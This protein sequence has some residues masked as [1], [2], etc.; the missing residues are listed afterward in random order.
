MYEVH[1]KRIDSLFATSGFP[2][3]NYLSLKFEGAAL[4]EVSWAQRF[5]IPKE[6]LLKKTVE[7][8]LSND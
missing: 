3:E 1:Q 4:N 6:F 2:H 7:K 8:G 5:S